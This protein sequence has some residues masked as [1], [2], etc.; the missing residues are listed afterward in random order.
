M[1][2]LLGWELDAKKA[3]TDAASAVILGV[4][5]QF[6]DDRQLIHFSFEAERLDKWRSE[7]RDA[8]CR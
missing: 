3:V 5:V 2:E 7:I 4:C 1:S 8:L 6:D